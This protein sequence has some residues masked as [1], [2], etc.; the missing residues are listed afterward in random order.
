VGGRGETEEDGVEFFLTGRIQD[1][2]KEI[3]IVQV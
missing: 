2:G 3:E 1:L